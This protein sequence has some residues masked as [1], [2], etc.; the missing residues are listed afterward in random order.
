MRYRISRFG[1]H[2]T[3]LIVAILYFILALVFVP[4]F[5]LASRGTSEGPFPPIVLILGPVF[6]A[7]FGYVFTAIGCWLYNIV[8]A[9][10]GGI[11]VTLEPDEAG[12]ESP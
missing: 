1:I 4:I 6:Y 3:A 9:Q 7:V 12:N 11:V 5:F 2:S 10:V 8:A